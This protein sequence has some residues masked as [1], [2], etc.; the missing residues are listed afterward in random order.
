MLLYLF[1]RVYGSV[2]FVVTL[3]VV[4]TLENMPTGQLTPSFISLFPQTLLCR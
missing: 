4:D 3:V 2:L 1:Y